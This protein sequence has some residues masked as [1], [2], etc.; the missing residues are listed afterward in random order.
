MKNIVLVG[1][2]GCG[3]ST[4]GKKLAQK[5]KRK[6]IDTDALIEEKTRKRIKDIFKRIGETA[7]RQAE[8]EVIKE[9]EDFD[10]VVIAC[11]GGAVLRN[12]NVKSL[13]KNGIIIYLKADPSILFNR[14][15]HTNKRPLLNT[16]HPEEQFYKIFSK[17]AEIYENIADIIVEA[18][19]EL[20]KVVEKILSFQISQ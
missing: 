14:V 20:D 19:E 5:L 6:F 2:M 1:F 8:T 3:K 17:R 16:R 9:I 13:K 15:K 7:F 10:N 12:R 11:G 18:E 4:V